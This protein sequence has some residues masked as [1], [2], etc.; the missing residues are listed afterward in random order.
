MDGGNEDEKKEETEH[1]IRNDT[2]RPVILDY[3]FP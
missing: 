1:A 3:G 2:R